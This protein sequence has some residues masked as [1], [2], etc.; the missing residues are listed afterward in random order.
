MQE[1]EI[2]L[3]ASKYTWLSDGE[4]EL[5]ARQHTKSSA[6]C[7]AFSTGA[8]NSSVHAHGR[9]KDHAA[10]VWT[11]LGVCQL[12]GVGVGTIESSTCQEGL[13]A[14]AAFALSASAK[15]CKARED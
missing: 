14:F 9:K 6:A 8:D 12:R 13:R 5:L 3:S 10:P 7:V 2:D 1:S 11:F 4:E 15:I